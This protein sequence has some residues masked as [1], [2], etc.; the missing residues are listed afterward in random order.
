M[1]IRIVKRTEAADLFKPEYNDETATVKRT[2]AAELFKPEYNDE[3]TTVK[4]AEAAELFKP[5]YNDEMATKSA[6]VAKVYI[7]LHNIYGQDSV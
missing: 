6:D 7:P 3:T 1:D 4:R 2:E 5:E